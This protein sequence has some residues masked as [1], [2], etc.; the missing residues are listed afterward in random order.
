MSIDLITSR[1][2]STDLSP[3]QELNHV[4]GLLYIGDLLFQATCSPLS[5]DL[6]E[7]ILPGED[8]NQ[9]RRIGLRKPGTDDIIS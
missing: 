5:V 6:H 3:L 7:L 4:E 8:A 1:D 9:H 2:A